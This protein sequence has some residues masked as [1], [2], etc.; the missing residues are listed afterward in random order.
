MVILRNQ[1][2]TSTINICDTDKWFSS[3]KRLDDISEKLV[4]VKKHL[5]S[6]FVF[7]LIKFVLLVSTAT[8]ERAFL[9]IKLIKSES[10]N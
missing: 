8:V 9:V 3:L 7:C 4:K 2:E 1:I 10:K 6:F 5:N